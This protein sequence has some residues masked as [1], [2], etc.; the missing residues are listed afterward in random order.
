[1]RHPEE[2]MTF[3]KEPGRPLPPRT[4]SLPDRP[5]PPRPPGGPALGREP[6]TL[7]VGREINLA[8][9]ITSCDRLVVEGEVRSDLERCQSLEIAR[10]GAFRG[11]AKIAS[12]EVA[13][14]FEG[15]LNVDG[16]LIL[17]AT[18]RIIGTIRYREI[19]IER[20][21]RLAGTVE[22]VEEVDADEPE[23]T[24]KPEPGPHAV[25]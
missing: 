23:E 25:T 15:E 5:K 4:A 18:G 19:E 7:T 3:A 11:K 20:G 24:K 14:L 9:E 10:D 13:G 2:S 8:G 21:G 16:C 1:M 6:K 22:V 12:A 17:R